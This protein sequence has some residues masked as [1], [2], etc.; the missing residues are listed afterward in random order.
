MRRQ[1][2]LADL[3]DKQD[4]VR[5]GLIPP[6]APKGLSAFP[7]LFFSLHPLQSSTRY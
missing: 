4:R 3:K 5:M 7:L 2:R 6:D 1:R